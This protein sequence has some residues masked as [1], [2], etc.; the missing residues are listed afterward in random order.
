MCIAVSGE[1][2]I[3]RRT[4]LRGAV[5]AEHLDEDEP[6]DGDEDP[7]APAE[8]GRGADADNDGC[9]ESVIQ[10]TYEAFRNRSIVDKAGATIATELKVDALYVHELTERSAEDTRA[11]LL[12]RLSLMMQSKS[13]NRAVLLDTNDQYVPGTGSV[14]GFKDLDMNTMYQIGAS[15][16]I[17]LTIMFGQPPSGLSTDDK[18]GRETFNRLVGE[19]Q[20]T[21]FA[22]PLEHM[23]TVL[24]AS[25]A[26]PTGG[27][28]PSFEIEFLP[29][30]VATP[31]EQAALQ[32]TYAEV[33][34][35]NIEL[36][37]YSP[38][39]AAMRYTGS[40]SSTLPP[41]EQ[42][43]DMSELESLFSALGE[44]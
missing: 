23:Y 11:N 16:G 33:D 17:A 34:K 1:G 7:G 19:Y 13:N 31:E 18:S 2:L 32:K 4:E 6:D 42:V 10:H 30:S 3:P 9:D 29:L 22:E 38:D 36:G 37:V 12:T 35:I 28:V 21:T 14:S 44:G 25:K 26:G 39:R 41:E 43:F 24:F 5:P 8:D 20:Q 27:D 15:T 40:F